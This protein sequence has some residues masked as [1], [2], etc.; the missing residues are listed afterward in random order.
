MSLAVF[1]TWKYERMNNFSLGNA[2]KPLGNRDFLDLV[3]CS[4]IVQETLNAW[5]SITVDDLHMNDTI[6]M[7]ALMS[8]TRWYVLFVD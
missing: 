3:L 1:G 5:I 7:I 4:S 2:E 6:L 8:R